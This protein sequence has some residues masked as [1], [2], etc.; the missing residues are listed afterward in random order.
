MLELHQG[1]QFA[2][3]VRRMIRRG[4]DRRE[5]ADVIE[6]LREYVELPPAYDAHVLEG[7]WGGFAECHI[8]DDWLLIYKVDSDKSR[9]TVV[10][11]GTHADLF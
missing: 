9:L 2:A 6:Y 4:A 8:N 10:R 7:E 3:D 5:L 11:T 1:S